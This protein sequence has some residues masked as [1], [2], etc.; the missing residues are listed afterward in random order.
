MIKRDFEEINEE[1]LIKMSEDMVKHSFKPFNMLSQQFKQFNDRFGT[2]PFNMEL[3]KA[4]EQLLD[5]PPFLKELQKVED[6]VSQKYGIPHATYSNN[7]EI[8]MQYIPE[9]QEAQR[10][11]EKMGGMAFGGIRPIRIDIPFEHPL[12]TQNK[13]IEGLML[14]TIEW[15]IR[16]VGV[17]KSY[18]NKGIQLYT[19][20]LDIENYGDEILTINEKYE[21]EL[22][23][24]NT[25]DIMVEY[26][27]AEGLIEDE[28]DFCIEEIYF[29]KMRE[30][31]QDE[32][33][34]NLVN[35]IIAWRPKLITLS[36]RRDIT[37]EDFD[38]FLDESRKFLGS[39]DTLLKFT[40]EKK[41]GKV[42]MG[43]DARQDEGEGVVL[44]FGCK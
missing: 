40:S 32:K 38:V 35:E 25:L 5:S 7:A 22:R 43:K 27:K 20:K 23:E 3:V 33:F 9:L 11:I 37:S 28:L 17:S 14:S 26:F 8:R 18:L 4:K 34:D 12:L 2:D 30:Y 19:R 42:E 1:I 39:G 44:D 31:Q 16:I 29:Y 10:E 36:K 6:L 21:F 15:L 41:V 24:I 13:I